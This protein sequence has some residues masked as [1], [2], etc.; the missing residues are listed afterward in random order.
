M[1]TVVGTA[2]G[3]VMMMKPVATAPPGTTTP[4]PTLATAGLLLDREMAAPSGGAG[5]AR[6]I[7]PEEPDVPVVTVGLRV[8]EAGGTGGVTVSRACTLA[9]FQLAVMVAGV[10]AAT[11]VVVT[12]KDTDGLPGATVTVA[13]TPTALELLARLTTA[14]PAG[15][16]PLS[17][18][19][20]PGA[21][22]PLMRVG[23]TVSP[24]SNGGL[25]VK[26]TDDG[27][28]PSEALTVTGVAVVT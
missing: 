10:S 22:P 4:D 28:A 14:P 24:L 5:E 20:P 27:D 12:V 17:M 11:V 2:A 1:V 19:M 23:V 3:A 16:A 8:S 7:T 26:A 25:T 9:P 6:V 13:G 15:A 21:P 18:T